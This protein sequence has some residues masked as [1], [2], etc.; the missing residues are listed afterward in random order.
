MILQLLLLAQLAAF[1]GI[2]GGG[3][4]SVGGRGG[5]ARHARDESE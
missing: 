2:V 5:I 3:A 1:P 4:A